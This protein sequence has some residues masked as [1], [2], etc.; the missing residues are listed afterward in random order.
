[1]VPINI[2]AEKFNHLA[3]TFD[4]Q[5]GLFPSLIWAFLL[6]SL[7]QELRIT[8]HLSLSV[9]EDSLQPLS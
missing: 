8:F 5:R 2:S 1:M 6:G 3:N 9:K 7:N 4:V